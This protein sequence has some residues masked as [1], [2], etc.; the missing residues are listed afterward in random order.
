MVE[1]GTMTPKLRPDAED[2]NVVYVV[3][4]YDSTAGHGISSICRDPDVAIRTAW[5]SAR[6]CTRDCNRE[7][8]LPKEEPS[9]G[10]RILSIQYGMEDWVWV[11]KHEVRG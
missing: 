9:T 5:A 4:Y 8:G 2:A 6:E 11:E 10:R 7:Y 1:E 3:M